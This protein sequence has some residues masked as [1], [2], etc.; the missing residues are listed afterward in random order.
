[1]DL[2]D[3]NVDLTDGNVD[4]ND[5]HVNLNVVRMNV[6]VYEVDDCNA[7]VNLSVGWVNRDLT[8]MKWLLD[9][10]PLLRPES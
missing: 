9:R 2:T 3:G 7:D 10:V 4:V 1:V 8:D 6:N 5:G